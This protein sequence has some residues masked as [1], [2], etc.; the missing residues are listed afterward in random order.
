MTMP[1]AV[2]VERGH[3]SPPSEEATRVSARRN[4]AAIRRLLADAGFGEAE[5]EELAVTYRFANADEL[6]FFVSELRGPVALALANLDEAERSAVRA[7]I[8]RRADRVGEGFELGGV[9]INVAT[10]RGA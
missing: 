9:S 4:P 3:L 1:A 5:I 6:W 10:R 8:E 2:M 7:E